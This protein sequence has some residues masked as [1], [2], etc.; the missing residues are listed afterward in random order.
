MTDDR[1]KVADAWLDQRIGHEVV[2]V[3][4]DH[5]GRVTSMKG[6]L[7]YVSAG[8][9]VIGEFRLDLGKTLREPTIS[10]GALRLVLDGEVELVIG[11]PK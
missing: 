8:L 2:L 6:I 11:S 3:R 10:R 1:P 5:D 4:I 7:N 9:Y